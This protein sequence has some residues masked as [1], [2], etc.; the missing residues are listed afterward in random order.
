M[1]LEDLDAALDIRPRHHDLPVEAARAEQRRI[2]HVGPVGG[3]D[4]DDAFVRFEPVHLDE[5]LVQGLLALVIAVAEAR[6]PMP[7]HRVDLVDAEIGSAS[8][9]ESVW[10]YV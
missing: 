8:C 2:E 4:D 9:R 5:E 10:Q 7:T 3:G 6:A 1:D